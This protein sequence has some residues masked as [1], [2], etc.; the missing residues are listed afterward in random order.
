MLNEGEC[1]KL[2]HFS[3]TI[4]ILCEK[5]KD[6]NEQF[7]SRDPNI[8]VW[9]PSI[10]L[11]KCICHE[12]KNICKD[13][14]P[15]IFNK[16][17]EPGKLYFE[18]LNSFDSVNKKMQDTYKTF[19]YFERYLLFGELAEID[20]DLKDSFIQFNKNIKQISIMMQR[21]KPMEWNNFIDLAIQE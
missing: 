20:E 1:Q 9:I 3:Q 15:D 2:I 14:I 7:E 8:F 11:L 19:N 13:F 4:S 18:V 10:L 6:I 5:Y 16:E 17:T 12:D 21:T